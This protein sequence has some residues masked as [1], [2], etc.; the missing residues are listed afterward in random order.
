MALTLIIILLVCAGASAPASSAAQAV[1][2]DSVARYVTAEMQRQKIPGLSVAIV[3]GSFPT[4]QPDT[5][6]ST[7]R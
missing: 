4:V 3:R 1:P 7:S 5:A 2:L 6:W